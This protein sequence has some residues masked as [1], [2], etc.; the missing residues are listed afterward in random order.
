MLYIASDLSLYDAAQN[1][2]IS[3]LHFHFAS[4]TAHGRIR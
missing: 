1:K 3:D 2:S 4:S